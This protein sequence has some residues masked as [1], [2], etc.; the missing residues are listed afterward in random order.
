MNTSNSVAEHLWRDRISAEI[1]RLIPPDREPT[2]LYAP[3]RYILE[4][5]GKRVRPMLVLL[6]TEACEGNPEDAVS[7]AL[8]VEVF[9][10]FTLVHDDIM[11]HAAT[12]R[13][14]PTVHMKW[15]ESTAILAGDLLLGESYRLLAA[16]PSGDLRQ[17]LHVYNTMVQRL[18]EGQALDKHFETRHDI[19]PGD[20]LHMIDGKTGALLVCCLELGAVI[21]NAPTAYRKALH[22]AGFYAGRAFQIQDDLLDLVADHE[23]WGKIPG[24]DLQEAK[25]TWLLLAAVERAQGDDAAFFGPVARGKGL[26][27]D[28][29]PEARARMERMGVIQAAREAVHTYTTSA[30]ASLAILPPSSARDSLMALVERLGARLH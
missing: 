6:A 19:T 21:A 24:G 12:R 18:C 7:A 4:T 8:A 29:I 26:V 15:D 28:A 27:A 14:R 1:S 23:Q 10:N 5:P 9:H 20:Y 3:S 25:K 2:A 17:L 16:T 22:Q 13:G 11:D 30:L